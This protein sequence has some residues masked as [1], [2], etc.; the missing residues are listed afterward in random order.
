LE[1]ITM[2][3]R[4]KG[5]S[6]PLDHN[7]YIVILSLFVCFLFAL[8][9]IEWT[10]KRSEEQKTPHRFL[11]LGSVTM[12][13]ALWATHF[14]G[15]LSI[16]SPIPMYYD[17]Q[18]MLL[19]FAA[20][21]IFSYVSFYL[22]QYN[23]QK[24]PKK[25]WAPV[26]TFSSGLILVH[27]IGLLSMNVHMPLQTDLPLILL[28]VS[29]AFLF[30][31]IGFRILLLQAFKF[32]LII[33]SLSL[34]SGVSLMHYI[35]EMA[36][37]GG[38]PTFNWHNEFPLT[39]INILS[40]LLVLGATIIVLVLYI[41]EQLDQKKI[42]QQRIELLESEHRYNSLFDLNP[43]GVFVIGPD[44]YFI[45]A[46]KSIETITGYTFEELQKIPYTN[47]LKEN[48]VQNS[49]NFLKRVM[50]G[51]TVKHPLTIYH[52]DGHEVELEITSLPYSL[53][54]TIT[55]VIG[56]AKDMTSINEA[57]DYKEKAQTLAYV[58]ELAA[59]LAHEVRN[60]LTSIKGFAQLFLSQ[61]SL[62]DKDHFLGIMLRE[63]ERINF[64]ISQ[65]MILAK[66]HM[67]IQ[68]EHDL[69]QIL[70]RSFKFLDDDADFH[71]TTFQFDLP[72]N[73]IFFKC[74]ENLM[75]QLFLNIFKNAL[76]AI[77]SWGTISVSLKLDSE[78]IHI[79][80][81]DDGLGIPDHI[82]PMLGQPFYTTKEGNPGLGLLICYQIVQHHGG[83]MSIESQEGCGTTVS[84]TFPINIPIQEKVLESSGV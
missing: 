1:E 21:I 22:L 10:Q 7:L 17:L 9:S 84:L 16:Q 46:N 50:E 5:G 4:K 42:V 71:S 51:D 58:G 11:L 65:L 59:G 83:K 25:L 69:N 13:I 24:L 81:Q 53:N 61:N 54:N 67:I 28:S 52:K 82:K 56:I 32:R 75:T 63:T 23:V 40:T 12:G 60:P 79:S 38:T 31:W 48:Q 2:G 77:P 72:G 30:S 78:N 66:P 19:A 70:K 29:F 55:A 27:G 80:I 43:E 18:T 76:E 3:H 35:G 14:M 49:L 73:P 41:L 74:E 6:V 57:Q 45:K 15:M 36:L 39:N 26:I 20:G 44:R 37:V 33:A 62:D 34:T 47:L 64:I 68:K 8:V